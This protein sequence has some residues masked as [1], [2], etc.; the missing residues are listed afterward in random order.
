M[1][2]EPRGRGDNREIRGKIVVWWGQ[3]HKVVM[4]SRLEGRELIYFICSNK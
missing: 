2:C 3:N 4:E 1:N